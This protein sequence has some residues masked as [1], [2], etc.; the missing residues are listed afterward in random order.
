MNRQER[1]SDQQLLKAWARVCAFAWTQKETNVLIELRRDPKTTI[2]KISKREYG[3]DETTA[4]R[5]QDIINT[6]TTAN[7]SYSGFLPIPSPEGVGVEVLGKLSEGVLK[8]LLAAGITGTL[9]FDDQPELWAKVFYAAWQDGNLLQDIRQDPLANLLR[10]EGLSLEA[11]E[12]LQNSTYG[13]LPIPDLPSALSEALSD[14]TIDQ[15]ESIEQLESIGVEMEN[16]TGIF[17]LT[18]C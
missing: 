8:D 2:E 12:A 14:N 1:S 18:A 17:P 9:R 7:Q 10:V 6:S 4:N 16:A 11:L 13:I 15:L 3:A 5:A